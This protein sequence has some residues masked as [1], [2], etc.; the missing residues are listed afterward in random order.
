MDGEIEVAF[1]TGFI[2]RLTPPREP[3]LSRGPSAGAAS[4]L[5][6]PLATKSPMLLA[7]PAIDARGSMLFLTSPAFRFATSPDT[8]VY[9]GGANR[10]L[11]QPRCS[12]VDG[13]CRVGVP[14]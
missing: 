6:N 9:R 12:S 5:Q 1:P 11:S 7:G 2:V 3:S 4:G 8:T 14:Q 10:R 13:D